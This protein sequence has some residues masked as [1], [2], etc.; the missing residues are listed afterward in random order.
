MPILVSN[1]CE[2]KEKPHV[3][4]EL[5][6]CSGPEPWVKRRQ[7]MVL[8]SGDGDGEDAAE[9]SDD[10]DENIAKGNRGCT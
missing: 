4:G 9:D 10:N 5:R 1:A 3:G 7:V 6:L 2:T 8:I